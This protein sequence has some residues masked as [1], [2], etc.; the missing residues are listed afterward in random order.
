MSH[1]RGAP[2]GNQNARKHG[3]Y[4]KVLTERDQQNL[5]RAAAVKG[6]DDE[7]ALL[8]VKL[9]SV[10]ERDP[11][12]LEL[13]SNAVVSIARLLTAR[14]KLVAGLSSISSLLP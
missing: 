9:K 3:F 2:F 1:K 11:D 7:I 5:S 4:S 14:N 13:I 12:N 10:V 8:R 6:L